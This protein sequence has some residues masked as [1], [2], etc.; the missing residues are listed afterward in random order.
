M[1][2]FLVRI[3]ISWIPA[4]KERS[5]LAMTSND[6][7]RCGTIFPLELLL[8]STHSRQRE[9][10]VVCSAETR[11]WTRSRAW[12]G[13][14]LSCSFISLFSFIFLF[15]SAFPRIFR[16]LPLNGSQIQP[17]CILYGEET[18]QTWV[19][20]GFNNMENIRWKSCLFFKLKRNT[21]HSWKH[22]VQIPF[23]F[24]IS[25]SIGS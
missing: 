18:T 5:C 20:W 7:K 25:F 14:R 1:S 6:G 8:S 11:I 24:C 22:D 2:R 23:S 10:S 19:A 17:R 21:A 12:D 3:S 9:S 15:L 4:L 13:L 16:I